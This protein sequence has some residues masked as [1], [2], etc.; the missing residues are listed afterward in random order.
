[1]KSSIPGLLSRRCEEALTGTVLPFFSAGTYELFP[2]PRADNCVF[3]TVLQQFRVRIPPFHPASV[4]TKTSGFLSDIRHEFLSAHFADRRFLSAAGEENADCIP[5]DFQFF[6]NLNTAEAALPQIC[7]FTFLGFGQQYHPSFT[8][9]MVTRS[10]FWP[11][12][13]KKICP[14]KKKSSTGIFQ[15]GIFSF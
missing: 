2:A 6:G 12:K 8:I 13:A 15:L 4:R 9:H 1:M 14:P 3:L 7:D 10:A 11:K 5:V